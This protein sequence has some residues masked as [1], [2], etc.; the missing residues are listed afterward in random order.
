MFKNFRVIL[1]ITPRDIMKFIKAAGRFVRNLL[2]ALVFS[3]ILLINSSFNVFASSVLKWYDEFFVQS[4]PLY[5]TVKTISD[6]VHNSKFSKLNE[7]IANWRKVIKQYNIPKDELRRLFDICWGH[8]NIAF[9][10]EYGEDKLQYYDTCESL[11]KLTIGC[12]DGKSLDD[13]FNV[14]LYGDDGAE[15]DDDGDVVIPV[16]NFVQEITKYPH[17]YKN[18]IKVSFRDELSKNSNVSSQ[19]FVNLYTDGVSCVGTDMN[20]GVYLLRYVYRD[21]RY[22]FSPYQYHLHREVGVGS[23]AIA[24]IGGVVSSF[25]WFTDP[26]SMVGSDSFE[27][28]CCTGYAQ[29]TIN[30]GYS[31][32]TSGLSVFGNDFITFSDENGSQL[33]G[34]PMDTSNDY[35]EKNPDVWSDDFYNSYV[36]L[37]DE[38]GSLCGLEHSVNNYRLLHST[39]E[40]C[41]H[42]MQ[43]SYWHLGGNDDVSST[44]SSHALTALSAHD[45]NCTNNCDFG[46]YVSSFPL[47]LSGLS[48]VPS[49]SVSSN[50]DVVL[51]PSKLPSGY[52]VVINTDNSSEMGD[53][54]YNYTI[55]N[56]ET[57]QKDTI[58]NFVT[59]NYTFTTVNNG[60]DNNS[61]SINGNITVGG[62]V[63]VGG[64]VDVDV[65]VN[66]SVP[67]I[68][69][70][71]NGGSGTGNSYEMPDITGFNDYFDDALDESSGIRKF[72]GDFF[73]TLP[74][75]I[76][77]LICFGLVLSILCRIFAR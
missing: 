41:S 63:E 29:S 75:Q 15:L 69:I 76:T 61:G 51:D 66:V 47:S 52:N 53:T 25:E 26:I 21:G 55:V 77:G 37:I 3:S 38:S 60:D 58:R 39:G 14:C 18:L 16:D 67:D 54:I 36:Y 9:I 33:V 12:L 8:D 73:S 34:T 10:N 5:Q 50:S 65:D 13:I 57:G 24:G 68:N 2:P 22:Y 30:F 17:L 44:A 4:T 19:S 35:Y 46:Y 74:G 6:N 64:R 48:N 1:R 40:M 27:M 62:R 7:C 28:S 31:L 70:N 72:I 32:Y 71:V 11:V 49:G 43:Y 20:D 59:N 23:G 45:G 42:V 56:P